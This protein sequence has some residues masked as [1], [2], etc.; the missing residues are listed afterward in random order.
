MWLTRNEKKVLKLLLNNAKI[1]DTSIASKLKISSQ[2]VGRIR[3]KL[4]EEVIK[5]YTINLDVSKLG[6]N[7]FVMCKAKLTSNGKELGKP[8]LEERIAK[9]PNI[10]TFY[11]LIGE[12][13]SYILV[14][15]FKDM[16]DLKKFFHS[17]KTQKEIHDY[18][19]CKE[20]TPMSTQCI[21]KNSIN[22]LCNNTIDHLGTKTAK[23]NFYQED[24]EVYSQG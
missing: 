4:E 8:I 9:N 12:E 11:E 23:P 15:G 17:E 10:I 20:I 16:Q 7:I 5:E 1:S 13:F 24:D 3:K 6:I 19:I 21:L 14:A 22:D 18:I 2:A